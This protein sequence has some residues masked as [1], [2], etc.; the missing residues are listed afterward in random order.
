M[1]L[2]TRLL[3]Y[4]FMGVKL[5]YEFLHLYFEKI[6]TTG[7]ISL[8]LDRTP[9][10]CVQT[11]VK[12]IPS[13]SPPFLLFAFSQ[14]FCNLQVFGCQKS[15]VFIVICGVWY[16]SSKGVNLGLHLYFLIFFFLTLFAAFYPEL[17]LHSFPTPS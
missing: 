5:C 15:F 7:L 17:I 16:F 10:R 14:H 1:A 4:S 3:V 6:K 8:I 11:G 13:W 2:Q 12:A 9:C